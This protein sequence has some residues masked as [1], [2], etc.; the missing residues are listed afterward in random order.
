MGPSKGLQRDV[1][2]RSAL[3][4]RAMLVDLN[5]IGQQVAFGLGPA[6]RKYLGGDT[7]PILMKKPAT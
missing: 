2:S 6:M 1:T 7:I 4:P 3:E 5:Q